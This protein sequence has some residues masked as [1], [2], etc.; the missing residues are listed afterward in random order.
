MIIAYTDSHLIL[1]DALAVVFTP[2]VHAIGRVAVRTFKSRHASTS[3]IIGG[4]GVDNIGAS[5]AV[6]ARLV[7]ARDQF[8]TLTQFT[9][10][11]IRT[12]TVE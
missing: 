4:L 8:K 9:S 2:L 10:E 11:L 5:R 6:F 1:I 12:L 7:V 3:E